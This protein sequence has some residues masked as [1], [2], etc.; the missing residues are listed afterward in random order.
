MRSIYDFRFSDRFIIWT[1][2]ASVAVAAAIGVLT[3][4]AIIYSN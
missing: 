1:V 4:T 3:V 2:C